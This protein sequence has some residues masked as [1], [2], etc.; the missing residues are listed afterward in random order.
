MTV[1]KMMLNQKRKK[2]NLQERATQLS[3]F[4]IFLAKD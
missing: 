2:S 3:G 4:F 1:P